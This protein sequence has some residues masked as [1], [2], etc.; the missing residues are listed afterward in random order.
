MLTVFPFLRVALNHL[1]TTLEAGEGHLS[2][3]V[4]LVSGLV[5][6]EKGSIGGEGEVNPRETTKAS[7]SL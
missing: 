1:I 5:G 3:R 2:D 6:R 7:A 4:L